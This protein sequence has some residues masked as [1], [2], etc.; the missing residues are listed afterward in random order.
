MRRLKISRE[1]PAQFPRTPNPMPSRRPLRASGVTLGT[2][3]ACFYEDAADHAVVAP[4][5]REQAFLQGRLAPGSVPSEM[6]H[7]LMQFKT[8]PLAAMHQ[9]MGRELYEGLNTGDK[10]WG[11][12]LLTGLSM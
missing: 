12:G 10:I 11:I 6:L 4:G 8:W 3:W 9:K 2:S 7:M 5:V 1:R